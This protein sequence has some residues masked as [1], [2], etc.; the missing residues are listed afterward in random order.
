MLF[1][2]AYRNILR[3]KRRSA[4]T[5]LAV[6]VGAVAL[7][8]FGGFQS[9]VFSGFQ[10]N[11]VQRS[12]HFTI[13]RRGYFL[14]GS[15]N[16]S[17]YGI[18]HYRSLMTTI[19]NDPVIAP[20][21]QVIT[22]V[23][24]LAG[25]AGNYANGNSAAK[26]FFGIG[27]VPSDRERMRHWNEFGTSRPY[28]ADD[29]LSDDDSAR[30]VVGLGLARVLGICGQLGVPHCPAPPTNR[31]ANASRATLDPGIQALARQSV[32]ARNAQTAHA[33]PRLDL[34]AATAAGAPNVV[35]FTVAGVEPQA[36]RELDDSYVGM[37]LLLAQ[38]LLYGRGQHKVSGIVLQLHR[39]EDM[40]LVKA[41]LLALFQQ[42]GLPLEVRDFTE[43]N[44]FYTQSLTFFRAIFLFIAVIMGV[45]VLFAVVN[46]MTMIVMERTTEIGMLRAIGVRRNAVRRQFLVEGALLGAIGATSGIAIA[47][48]IAV[49]IA[50]AGLTWTPPGNTIATPV[51]I[52]LFGKWR[53]IFGVSA[54][55][56]VVATIAALTPANR[57][58][59]LQVVDALRHA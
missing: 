11:V 53:F 59:K 14:F 46:T 12:G 42:H 50:H 34:L 44:P 23:L 15:G 19:S 39:T 36:A 41:R 28:V 17:A 16:P 30:G 20:R 25:I 51:E 27:V 13:F 47:A 3:N 26:T 56:V 45:I 24:S 48:I 52:A 33:S 6:A 40:P 9:Y 22:P 55:L 1:K 7:L 58:A 31:A 35:T 21:L 18:D 57:A 54:I 4:A 29:L 38:Q 43:L 32:G 37:N 8:V 5:I 2:I 49:L 10:T